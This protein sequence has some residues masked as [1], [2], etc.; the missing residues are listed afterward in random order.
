[1]R[2]QP[3]FRFEMHDYV[4]E[5]RSALQQVTTINNIQIEFD[6]DEPGYDVGSGELPCLEEGSGI[7]PQPMR[8]EIRF[9]I[10]IPFRIQEELS[11][12]SVTYE[13]RSE[14]FRLHIEYSFHGPVAYVEPLNAT[15]IFRPSTAVQVVREYLKRELNTNASVIVFECLGPSPFHA[16]FYLE[17]VPSE[18]EES[19]GFPFSVEHIRTRGYAEVVFTYAE[20]F[21]PNRDTAIHVLFSEL[22]DELGLFY[23]AK[24]L[25]LDA[26]R[27]WD[28]IQEKFL[29][30]T[31]VTTEAGV[32]RRIRAMWQRG[33]DL[34]LLHTSL[35]RFDA[36]QLL[37]Q[38][39]LERHYRS[40]Y[41]TD[42]PTYLQSFIT[43]E[44]QNR[45][46]F[47]TQ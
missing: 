13:T 46:I 44:V 20:S 8:L 27:D 34:H 38:N 2:K 47:P 14:N 19:C 10:Y 1:M 41:S 7:F 28:G 3:P 32:R 9:D 33:R 22:S 11:R 18:L 5:L 29:A 26:Y 25:D 4:E 17:S 23:E 16:D 24:R 31:D 15:G 43:A 6:E 45:P 40:T 30:L 39:E 42:E 37:Q 35:V 12:V 36:N 21:F